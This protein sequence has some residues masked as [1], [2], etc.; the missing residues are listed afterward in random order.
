MAMMKIIVFG[1]SS[2]AGD[3]KWRWGCLERIVRYATLFFGMEWLKFFLISGPDAVPRLLRNEPQPPST[4]ICKISSQ[5]ARYDEE[6]CLGLHDQLP[7]RSSAIASVADEFYKPSVK[8]C[9][10]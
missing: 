8:G 5:H 3:G 9:I 10:V 1:T 2:C 4:W 6:T 7:E